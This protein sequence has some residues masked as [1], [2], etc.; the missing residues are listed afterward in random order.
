[1]NPI[2]ELIA[3][4]IGFII[5]LSIAVWAFVCL[6]SYGD[7]YD[8]MLYTVHKKDQNLNKDKNKKDA[9]NDIIHHRQFKTKIKWK[10][11]F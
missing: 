7:F 11:S 2:F 3:K 1:M 5:I 4:M 8:K 10:Q 9:S 6:T